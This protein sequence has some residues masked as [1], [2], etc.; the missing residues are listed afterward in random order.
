M[1]KEMTKV[2][3]LAKLIRDLEVLR[4]IT[5]EQVRTLPGLDE[6]QIMI[7]LEVPKGD[8]NNRIL[9]EEAFKEEFSENVNVF[10]D[11]EVIQAVI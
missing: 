4:V 11:S 6:K 3:R 1:A 10:G 2:G 5:A 8:F 9:V 7:V